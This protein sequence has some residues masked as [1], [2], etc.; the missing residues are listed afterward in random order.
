MVRGQINEETKK[1][2]EKKLFGDKICLKCGKKN[3]E[4]ATYC[5]SCGYSKRDSERRN[6]YRRKD[7]IPRG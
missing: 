6:W 7:K 5:R 3:P 4:G 2:I 1:I